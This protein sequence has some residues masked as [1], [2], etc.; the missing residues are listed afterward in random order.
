[1]DVIYLLIP[2]SIV[3][4]VV[5][6]GAFIWASRS[7]QFEDLERHGRDIFLE[8]EPPPGPSER[9]ASESPTPAL[10]AAGAQDR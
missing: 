4:V 6:A 5:I 10:P 9:D 7:G 1:M 2:V 3:L 8:P